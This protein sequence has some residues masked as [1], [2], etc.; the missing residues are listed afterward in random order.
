M[1][2]RIVL[3]IYL[4]CG[5]LGCLALYEDQVGKFDWRQQFIGRVRHVLRPGMQNKQNKYFSIIV[6]LYNL[7]FIYKF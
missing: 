6:M 1:L 5:P 3:F 2:F 7:M 4:V